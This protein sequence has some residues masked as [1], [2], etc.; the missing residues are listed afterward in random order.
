MTLMSIKR[1][2]LGRTAAIMTAVAS[3]AC[4]FVPLDVQPVTRQ[5]QVERVF[6]THEVLFA[7][8]QATINADEREKLAR[9]VAGL[10]AHQAELQIVGFADSRAGE[11]YNLELSARRAEAVAAAVERDLGVAVPVR[12]RA[13]G[14]ARPVVGADDRPDLRLSRRVE[15][16]ATTYVTTIPR[17]DL[18]S[19][20][21]SLDPIRQ[22][23]PGLGCANDAN[24]AAMVADPRDLIDGQPT[25]P[26]DGH[27]QAAG[28]ERYHTDKVKDLVVEGNN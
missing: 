14:E 6:L 10:T 28:V 18:F 21:R 2:W 16:R 20:D 8:D 9:F 27:H 3:T 26:A 7:T 22:P 19:S 23:L 1:A 12:V 15:V 4:G 25:G 11:L 17:C 5:P 24:L 13:L